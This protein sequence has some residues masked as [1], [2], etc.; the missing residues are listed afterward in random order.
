MNGERPILRRGTA[1][2][3]LT[4]AGLYAAAQAEGGLDRESRELFDTVFSM[5]LRD[6][7]DPKSPREVIR[8]ALQGAAQAAGPESAYIPPEEVE[9]IA[10]KALLPATL[11]LYATKG[12][13]FARILAPFPGAPEALRPGAILRFVGKMSTYDL[14]YPQILAAFRGAEGEK[15]SLTVMDPESWQATEVEVRRVPFPAP[16]VLPLP[17]GASAL[18]LP[19]LEATLP[20]KAASALRAGH[21][22][23]VV[24]LR[25]CASS[26]AGDI[27]RWAGLLLGP[28]KGPRFQR[29]GGKEGRER[30]EGPGLL[31]G[32]AVRVLVDGTTARGGEA[33]ASALAGAGAL[34]AG[35]PTY[36]TAVRVEE[37]PLSDGGRLRLA[38]AFYLAPDGKPLKEHPIEP[39]LS[40]AIPPGEAPEKT[41]ATLLKAS[42]PPPPPGHGPQ[43]PKPQEAR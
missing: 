31:S 15:V 16:S 28:G 7:V 3:L 32:K 30:A 39:A 27:S 13:D 5:V 40:L 19:A 26:E 1:L 23:W 8:G 34:L 11:P 38:T 36:G 4:T 22:P 35:Q 2:L 9:A 18:V 42:A 14:T 6:Y 41:Y 33:L 21:G 12:E 25:R 10:R 43:D 17:G 20:E 29:T 37:I 24:D